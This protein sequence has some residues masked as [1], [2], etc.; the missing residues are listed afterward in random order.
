MPALAP[1]PAPAP[2]DA[3]AVNALL[4]RE[5]RRVR[6][7]AAMLHDRRSV[8]EL[9]AYE[10]ELEAQLALAR[11]GADLLDAALRPLK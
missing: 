8:A 3:L 2:T 4:D 9:A 11:H 1:A 6:R 10:R 7:V 5:L